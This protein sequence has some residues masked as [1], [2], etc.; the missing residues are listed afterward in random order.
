MYER[1]SNRVEIATIDIAPIII[2]EKNELINITLKLIISV[3]MH[4]KG[5]I[6]NIFWKHHHALCLEI[7]D[8]KTE[9]NN[10]TI[11]MW[12]QNF[13]VWDKIILP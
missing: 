7:T 3:T 2:E 1:H 6:I 5:K 12:S 10:L 4:K 9:F 13:S 11:Q 8:L